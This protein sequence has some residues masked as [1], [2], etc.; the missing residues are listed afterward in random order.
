MI[1]SSPYRVKD[2]PLPT[3]KTT[4]G[5]LLPA[6]AGPAL[7][8]PSPAF[9]D[10]LLGQ[11]DALVLFVPAKATGRVLAG[12]PHGK[13][14]ATRFERTARRPG[15]SFVVPLPTGRAAIAVV[16]LVPDGAPAFALLELAGKMLKQL[17]LQEVEVLGLAAAG[18]PSDVERA[19]VEAGAAAALAAAFDL[20][21]FKSKPAKRRR[22]ARIVP[23]TA[24]RLDTK[25]LTAV[26]DGTNLVRWL[27]SMP[28]DRLDPAGF[29]RATMALAKRHGLRTRFY[30]EAEL[31]RLGA[32]AFLAVT[33]GSPRRNAGILRVS[34]APPGQRSR[35]QPVA[36]VGKGLCFDTGGTNLKPHKGM[37]E[38]H[39][40]MSGSAV[41]L[42]SLVTLARLGYP[43]P[44]EA[45]LALAENRIGPDAYQP[46]EVV[47]A[48]DGTTIQVIHTDAEGRMVLADTLALA[49][50][51]KPAAIV[52]FATLTGACVGALTERYS[53]AFTDREGWRPAIERA[54]R[55]SGERVWCLPMDEDFDEEIDSKVA[56]V[57]QCPVDGKG[58]HIYAARFLRR[59]VGDG[60]PWLHVDLSS[61]TRHGGLAHVPTEVTGF[62]V[63]F[64]TTLLLDAALPE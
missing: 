22:L 12:L 21:R 17:D 1:R 14:L 2:P 9:T 34:Y 61:A 5:A 11:L 7:A 24:A 42:A 51:G 53:G 30:G 49:S 15:G 26:A 60:I 20:P 37:L 16:G 50:R 58:D 43:R 3:R 10:A 45:W 63:R 62:G 32:G 64:L 8:R 55:E 38:M 48:V 25:R 13:L 36:L 57:V 19:C 40:D 54:G 44:V 33:R 39:T 46:Q 59:F 4:A 23:V 56:D 41:A 29:R 35:Q 18:L 27:T 28:P 31:G 47:T 6:A 52:D